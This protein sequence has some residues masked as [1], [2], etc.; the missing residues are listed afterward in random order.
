[1][2]GVDPLEAVDVDDDERERAFM[3]LRAPRLGAQLLVEGAVVGKVRELV[4]CGERRQLGACVGERD[5]GLRRERELRAAAPGP[6]SDDERAPEP[7]ADAD[8]GGSGNGLAGPEDLGDRLV[9]LEG[10]RRAG[11]EVHGAARLAGADDRAE[12]TRLEADDGG[13]IDAQ[14]EGRLLGNDVEQL[15]GVG[16]ERDRI[17]DSLLGGARDQG[18]RTAEDGHDAGDEPQLV[19]AGE[20][21][22]F[23]HDVGPVL[24]HVALRAVRGREQ[25]VRVQ[26]RVDLEADEL[27]C[28]IAEQRLGC[29]RGRLDQALAVDLQ[30][31]HVARVCQEPARLLLVADR[32]LGAGQCVS[33]AFPL[34][35]EGGLEHSLVGRT[36]AE[37]HRRS[38]EQQHQRRT[39]EGGADRGDRG[40]G[41]GGE[42][43]A[44]G[45]A[46]E[47]CEGDRAAA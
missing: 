7:G 31:E 15:D 37:P 12:A 39:R 27:V 14:V 44:P 29:G 11:H 43:D 21:A 19:A 22:P 25:V 42:R 20:P 47:L 28:R 33:R 9:A 36:A 3:A 45:P 40:G 6:P 17:L 16:L 32:G 38:Y 8:G 4:A 24:V 13:A 41:G 23:E 1:M 46:A 35:H 5:R 10:D 2:L 30:D 18:G 34:V 26:E